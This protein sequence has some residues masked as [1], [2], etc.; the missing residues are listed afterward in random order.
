MP[1][2]NPL[3]IKMAR[4]IQER[5]QETT[6][7]EIE[8]VFSQ[9][10]D[11]GE[12][13]RI[14]PE[15]CGAGAN[16]HRAFDAFALALIRGMRVVGVDEMSRRRRHHCVTVFADMEARPTIFESCGRIVRKRLDQNQAGRD[17]HTT[18]ATTAKPNPPSYR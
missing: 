10:M 4:I 1:H 13:W 11:L 2:T 8:Q 3:H 12:E 7:M 14:K 5:Q 17:N 18:R 9:E 6:G 15:F 16:F